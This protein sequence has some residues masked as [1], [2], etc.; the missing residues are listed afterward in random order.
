MTTTTMMKHTEW[1][2]LHGDDQAD[3]CFSTEIHVN[4]TT[5]PAVTMG[6][7][8]RVVPEWFAIHAWQ[9]RDGEPRIHLGRGDLA[10]L[11]MTAA[12]AREIATALTA[13]ANTVEV[14]H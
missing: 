9:D 10:G 6:P 7:P 1:C 2:V 5:Y 3:P 13:T 8:V 11:T 12:E 4:A 14:T